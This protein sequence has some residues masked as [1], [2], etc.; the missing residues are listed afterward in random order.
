[1]NHLS[2]KVAIVTGASRGIG[3]EIAERLAGS[4]AKV[5]INFASNP[6]PAEEVVARIKA[7]GGEAIAVRADVSRVAEIEKLFLAALEAYGQIDILVNNAGIMVTKPLAAVTE[8]DY[9]QQFAINAKGTFFACQQALKHMNKGG[10]I[11]NFSTSVAGM[12]FPTYSVYVGSKGAVEQFSRQLAKE[13]SPAGI[14][15]NTVAPGPVNTELF[16]AGK[17]E[18]QIQA[19]Q[20]LNAFGRLGEPEDIAGVVLFLASEESRWITGQTIRVNGG[21]V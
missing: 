21:M 19:I 10:R 12:M 16:T 14:T 18:Q 17:S 11:I 5:I 2:G 8:E 4:G 7:N 1:M 9:D 13:F 20:N 3:R 15:I 6:V